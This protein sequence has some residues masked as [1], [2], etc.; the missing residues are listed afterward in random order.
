MKE[1]KQKY[2]EIALVRLY[3]CAKHTKVEHALHNQYTSRRI[4]GEWFIPSV[5]DTIDEKVSGLGGVP[6]V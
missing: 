5:L 2:G 4:E 1:L 3:R 6:C